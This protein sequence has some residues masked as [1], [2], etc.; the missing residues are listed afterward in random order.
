MAL[1]IGVGL[2]FA[3]AAFARLA[4]LDRDRAFYPT[5]LIVVGAFYVLFAAMVGSTSAMRVEF[6]FFLAFAATAVVGFRSSLWIAAAGLAAHGLFDFSR[7]SFVPATGA[8]SWWPAFCGGFDIAAGAILAV[9][10]WLGAR[11]ARRA[12]DTP[13]R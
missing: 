10:L 4:G 6:F 1:F 9:L 7:H 12:G 8:P 5:V 13:G 11:N 2:A 3:V